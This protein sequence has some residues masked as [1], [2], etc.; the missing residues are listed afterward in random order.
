MIEADA[1]KLIVK[2]LESQDNNVQRSSVRA[3]GKMVEHGAICHPRVTFEL[4]D[5]TQRTSVVPWLK[6]VL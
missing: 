2:M 4:T 6:G 3:V 1:V 5:L